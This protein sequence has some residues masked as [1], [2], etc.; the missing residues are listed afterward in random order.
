M[1][2]YKLPKTLSTFELFN[3][4]D[5]KALE[6][7]LLK[8]LLNQSILFQTCLHLSTKNTKVMLKTH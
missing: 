6:M 5:F 4:T 1:S 2:C 7:N 3:F 8:R